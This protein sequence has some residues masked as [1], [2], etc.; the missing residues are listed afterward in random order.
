MK[1]RSYLAVSV[2]ASMLTLGIH[3]SFGGESAPRKVLDVQSLRLIDSAGTVRAELA[4]DEDE[5]PSLTF[6]ASDGT[7]RAFWFAADDGIM[8]AGGTAKMSGFSLTAMDRAS[9]IVISEEGKPCLSAGYA[10]NAPSL[11]AKST[12]GK[13]IAS[14]P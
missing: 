6:Y 7:R 2:A 13:T 11:L 9:M 12:D 4:L 10:L 5:I 8:L 1:F 3:G 14:W